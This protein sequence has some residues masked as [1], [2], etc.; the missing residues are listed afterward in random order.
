MGDIVISIDGLKALAFD[1]I[2]DN[3]NGAGM[4]VESEDTLFQFVDLLIERTKG[5]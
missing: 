5:V 4:S 1:F 3:S 2:K